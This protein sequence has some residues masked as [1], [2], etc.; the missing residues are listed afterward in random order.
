[1]MANYE[2][3]VLDYLKRYKIGR[4][5]VDTCSLRL[6]Q[7]LVAF[8]QLAENLSAL[9]TCHRL[10]VGCVIVPLDLSGIAAIGYNGV[11]AGED[12]QGC[13]GEIGA[14]RCIHAEANALIKF[15]G[16]N[17]CLLITTVSPCDHCAGLIINSGSIQAVI[18]TNEYRDVNGLLRLQSA[19]IITVAFEQGTVIP[20][21]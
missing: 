17:D 18:Y 16:H 15:R 1:M 2:N 5:P 3:K 10:K 9:S 7:K 13:T 8:Y 4:Q 14:C 21:R 11:P 20:A 19:G 6:R 12:N